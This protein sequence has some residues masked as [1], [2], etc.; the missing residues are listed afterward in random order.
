[1]N[2]W[3]E[4]RE[5]FVCCPQINLGACDQSYLGQEAPC[6]VDQGEDAPPLTVNRQPLDELNSSSRGTTSCIPT[7][8]AIANA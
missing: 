8:G 3:V 5:K 2:P 7:L 1:M 6:L 4:I